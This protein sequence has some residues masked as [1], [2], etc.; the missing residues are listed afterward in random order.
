MRKDLVSPRGVVRISRE[1]ASE[2]FRV[3]Q[4]DARTHAILG[5]SPEETTENVRVLLKA[6]GEGVKEETARLGLPQNE[7][8]NE[9]A[10]Y[11]N[12]DLDADLRAIIHHLAEF[13]ATL[14]AMRHSAFPPHVKP[15]DEASELEKKLKAMRH[16]AYSAIERALHAAVGVEFLTIVRH[17]VEIAAHM[18]A[19]DGAR[20]SGN[21]R[22]K[23][24]KKR[25]VLVAREFLL[26]RPSARGSET[27]LK[28]AVG[29][30]FGLRRTAAIDA[31]NQGLRI[32]SAD[33]AKPDD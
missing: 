17:E 27:A 4:I 33:P 11:L 1:R 28:A 24:N 29:R 32:L 10:S 5:P 2:G 19:L 3:E 22:E 21:A 9:V 16:S 15:S 13:E 12:D 18:L 23:Q 8:G 31:V 14:E 6:L 26:C 20:R 30:K 7:P 25:N